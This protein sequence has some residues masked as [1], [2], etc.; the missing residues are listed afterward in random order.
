MIRAIKFSLAMSVVALAGCSSLGV[1]ESDFSCNK[2]PGGIPCASLQQAYSA[3][4]RTMNEVPRTTE[5][6]RIQQQGITQPDAFRGILP[7]RAKDR[8]VAEGDGQVFVEDA[9]VSHIMR[10]TMEPAKVLRIWVAPWVDEGQTLHWPTH[11]F[12]E[13]TPR[14]WSYGASSVTASKQVLF[15][16]QVDSARDMGGRSRLT[17]PPVG[18]TPNN[19]SGM[20]LQ[21]AAQA[22]IPGVAPAALTGK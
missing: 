11:L 12:T 16:V 18:N 13:I 4:N 10:P 7:M 17:T 19:F 15:P 6:F 9:N 8:A 1:G 21:N 2:A 3:S 20:N 22:L 5:E 14:K